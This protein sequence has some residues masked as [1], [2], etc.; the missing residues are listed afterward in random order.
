MQGRSIREIVWGRLRRDRVAMVCLVILVVMYLVAILGPFVLPFFGHD[1][2]AFDPTSISAARGG[3]PRLPYGG[4]SLLHPLGVEWGTGRDIMSQLVW[5]LRISLVISTTATLITVFIGTVVGIVAGYFGGWLD[6][7]VGRIM[8]L[9][10]CFP[11]LLI[12]LALSWPLT[13]RLTDLGVPAGNP[14]R[15]LYLILAI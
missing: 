12:I 14:S 5:G 7:V 9:I 4:I 11:F 1:P 6:M 2:Y 10:L 3:A 8:D 13:D 15:I